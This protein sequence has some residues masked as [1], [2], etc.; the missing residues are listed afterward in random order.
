MSGVYTIP[1]IG[2]VQVPGEAYI[3]GPFT[4]GSLSLSG[5][6]T[7]RSPRQGEIFCTEYNQNNIKYLEVFEW[8][9]VFDLYWI[10]E[11][12]NKQF[13]CLYFLFC[14][15]CWIWIFYSCCSLDFDLKYQYG[16]FVHLN[17]YISLVPTGNLAINPHFVS[18]LCVKLSLSLLAIANNPK[19]S[20][21]D[22]QLFEIKHLLIL[23]EQIVPFQVQ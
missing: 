1:Y 7:V 18:V 23:R 14:C 5:V 6:Y 17:C 2:C 9:A 19:K 12:N 10:V 15:W 4:G 8:S 20:R 16:Q 13:Q 21:A 22:G 3:P 11:N